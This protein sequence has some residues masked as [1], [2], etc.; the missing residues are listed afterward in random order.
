MFYL[1]DE[2]EACWPSQE[3]SPF[4]ASAA[5]TSRARSS[6]SS[7]THQQC[8]RRWWW[9]PGS[10]DS[11]CSLARQTLSRHPELGLENPLRPD[12]QNVQGPPTCYYRVRPNLF[13]QCQLWT[14]R[15]ISL[16]TKFIFYSLPCPAQRP[17]GQL[18]RFTSFDQS[19]PCGAVWTLAWCAS[20]ELNPC[21]PCG[22]TSALHW[23][24]GAPTFQMYRTPNSYI[25][26]WN[27]CPSFEA[28]SK[29][30]DS[31]S[32]PILIK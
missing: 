2:Q 7:N 26:Q 16:N 27:V 21:H 18:N 17:W 13:V 4:S 11:F 28:I 10:V 24:I 6:P 3:M 20:L 15:S 32:W 25:C 12:G 22:Q 19:E 31:K 23:A 1:L 14:C 29:R 9:W 8:R 30:Q 5:K